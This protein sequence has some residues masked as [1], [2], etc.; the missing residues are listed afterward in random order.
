M[1]KTLIAAAAAVLLLA[2]VI[3]TAGCVASSD[4]VEGIWYQQK[5]N[6]YNCLVFEEDGAGYFAYLADESNPSDTSYAI[7]V[8]RKMEKENV[9]SLQFPDGGEP[10]LIT[11]DRV[12]GIITTGDGDVY[13][14]IPDAAS[15]ASSAGQLG[16]EKDILNKLDGLLN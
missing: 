1:R 13:M 14:K 2:A 16:K 6:A 9:Y 11:V 5:G 15:G 10:V 8:V 4:P 12:K 7:P 3:L